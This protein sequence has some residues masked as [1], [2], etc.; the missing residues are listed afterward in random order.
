MLGFAGL[1]VT[2]FSFTD[3]WFF[4][5]GGGISALGGTSALDAG[6]LSSAGS[7][8]VNGASVLTGGFW[9]GVAERS[10]CA[11]GVA[12]G[13]V[14]LPTRLCFV[15][16]RDGEVEKGRIAGGALGAAALP[17]ERALNRNVTDLLSD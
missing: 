1:S 2:A 16:R 9:P 12:L 14:C 13:L 8:D 5:G 7:R 6:A 15:M 4:G 17:S 11:V 3:F 10:F